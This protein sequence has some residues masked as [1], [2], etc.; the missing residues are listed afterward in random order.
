VAVVQ[1][2]AGELCPGDEERAEQLAMV[3]SEVFRAAAQ[4]GHFAI[5][6]YGHRSA[7]SG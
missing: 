2:I 4:V 3:V 5:T 6:A 7:D 1:R